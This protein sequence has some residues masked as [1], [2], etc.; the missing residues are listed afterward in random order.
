MHA[1]PD[2]SGAPGLTHEQAIAHAVKRL[3]AGLLVAFPTETVYGLGAD[4]LNADAVAR[5]FATKGRP[6]HNPLIVHVEGES[7]M[8]R[9][10]GLVAAWPASARSLAAAFWPGPLTI[11][12]PKGG[13]VPDVVTA[14]GGTVALRSP[15]H[16]VARAL[17]KAFG[18]PLVGPSANKS[19]RVSPTT[20][21]HVRAE[22]DGAD[23]FVLDGGPCRVG[24]ESTVV[25]VVDVPRVLRPGSISRETIEMA[26]G[27]RVEGPASGAHAASNVAPLASP[28]LLA[29]HYAPRTRVELIAHG[30]VTRR[31]RAIMDAGQR[32]VALASSDA[33]D[34][35]WSVRVMPSDPVAYAAE[36]Y[37]A[38]READA[39]ACD[40]ILV[41][42]P[43]H[44]NAPEWAAVMDR[45]TRASAPR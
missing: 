40:V 35:R 7:A 43:A 6:A 12:V 39:M 27:V 20:A 14:G 3:R 23:V 31:A 25:S 22:F 26:L 10:P 45:L 16:P 18:G 21:D 28:G 8:A 19:G 37:A 24:I 2:Q 42:L 38:L 1:S 5:V 11:V 4:A 36:M 17:L 15:D 32:V 13:A 34:S 30:E 9:V 44:A 29:S 41:E 33:G